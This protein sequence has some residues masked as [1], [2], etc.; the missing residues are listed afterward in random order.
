M[1][2]EKVF[3]DPPNELP[4][5]KTG[6][7]NSGLLPMLAKRAMDVTIAL[8][9]LIAA[10]PLVPLVWALARKASGGGA[11]FVQDDFDVFA[12][13]GQGFVNAVVDD[14]L[15]QVIGMGRIGVHAGAAL[16]GF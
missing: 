5:W 2:T 10:A 14:F 11:I 16:Y 13:T 3:Y 1:L 15:Y 7:G 12:V 9:G 6:I 8:T 4:N